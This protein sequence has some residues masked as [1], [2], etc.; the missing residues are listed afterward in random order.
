MVEHTE[1]GIVYKGTKGGLTDCGKDTKEHP[2][3]WENTSKSV[4]CQNCLR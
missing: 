1:T 2:S 4:T 3:H